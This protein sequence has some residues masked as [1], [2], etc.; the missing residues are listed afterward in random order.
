M[1]DSVLDSSQEIAE[2]VDVNQAG[3]GVGESRLQQNMPRFVLAEHVINEIGGHRHLPPGLF[4]SGV[5]ALDQPRNDGA[6]PEGALHQ[7]RLREP[8]VEV[9]TKHVL[10]EEPGK[11][12]AAVPHHRTEI[13]ESPDGER[14]FV[15][16]K[17]ERRRS[18]P[19]EPPRQEHAEALM[20]EPALERIADE[21]VAAPARK[22]LDQDLFGSGTSENSAWRRSQSDTW[23]GR[24]C[25]FRDSAMRRRTRSVR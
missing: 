3:R 22:R 14:V 6:D 10:V 21:I 25:Q 17:A 4:L 9:V 13:A 12:E 5:A 1:P 20:R 18:R 24:R 19:V 8:G 23:S 11:V 7:A 16:D 2:A 15:G